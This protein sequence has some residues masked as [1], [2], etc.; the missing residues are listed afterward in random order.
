VKR[1]AD[2]VVGCVALD[3]DYGRKLIS[4]NEQIMKFGVGA[5]EVVLFY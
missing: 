3:N 2:D 4:K 5:A 1:R